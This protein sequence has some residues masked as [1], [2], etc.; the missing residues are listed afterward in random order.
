[1]TRRRASGFT[2]V[3]LVVALALLV[4]VMLGLLTALRSFGQSEAKI[5]ARIRR[6]AD[7]RSSAQFLRAI[8]GAMAPRNPPGQPGAPRRVDFE[9]RADEVRW[10]GV[11]PA[12]HGAGGLYRFRLSLQ[13][14][15]DAGTTLLLQFAPY[16]AG[17]EA[18]IENGAFDSRVL[19]AEVTSVT[20]RYLDA[21]Q[22]DAQWSASWTYP[23]RLP[24]RIGLQLA[25]ASEVWPEIIVAITP[26]AGPAGPSRSGGGGVIIGPY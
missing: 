21:A 7:L 17:S 15:D 8:L 25:T 22:A 19:A 26:A 18:P 1:M 12:R 14:T 23:D 3:E 2:L 5:D 9:G 10:V 20:F 11:M 16:V 24:R 6:D 13:P 4:L